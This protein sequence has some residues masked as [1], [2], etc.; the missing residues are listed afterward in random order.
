MNK[1]RTVPYGYQIIN[2]EITEKKD[3]ADIVRWIFNRYEKGASY[4]KIAD[5]LTAKEVFYLENKNTWNKNNIKRILEN[6]KYSGRED[7]TALI[8]EENF[9]AVQNIIAGK[10]KRL[11]RQVGGNKGIR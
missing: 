9:D 3:E 7:T 8:T 11:H 2:G 5:I 10:I 1:N 6:R 4:K